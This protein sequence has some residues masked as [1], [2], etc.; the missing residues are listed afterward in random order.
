M[1]AEHKYIY[2]YPN[3]HMHYI[4]RFVCLSVC[5]SA[6]LVYACSQSVIVKMYDVQNF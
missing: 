3:T 2:I 1:Y 5:L 4:L 6:R